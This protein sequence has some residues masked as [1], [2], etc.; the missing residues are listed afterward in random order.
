M[1]NAKNMLYIEQIVV[2]WA[3]RNLGY[4][5]KLIDAA[6]DMAKILEVNQIVLGVWDFNKGAE[7]F[8]VAQG[9][10]TIH[11]RMFLKW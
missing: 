5:K 4:G 3:Y 10:T 1:S 7:A 2:K 8:F 9:F 11:K 6:K